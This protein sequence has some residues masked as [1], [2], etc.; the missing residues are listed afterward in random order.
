MKITL[1]RALKLRKE[2]EALLQKIELPTSVAVSLL[3]E[4][5]VTNP[6]AAIKPGTEALVKRIDNYL[7]LSQTLAALRTE[8][9]KANVTHGVEATL[10]QAAHHVRAM[11]IYKKLSSAGVT[12]VAEQLKAELAFSHQS[13]QNKELG[14]GRP[15]RSVNVSV[16]LP[17]L[18]DKAA[19]Q[20]TTWKRSLE[21][22]EDQRTGTNASVQIEI[23]EG[24]A[25]LLRQQGLI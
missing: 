12:P 8:I 9:A 24:D 7:G 17:E 10:A 20:Y 21:A 11:T 18:R 3:I 13:L 2:L 14:Y 25:E 5:N 4:D 15:D 23:A 22:L 6:E 19:E 1:K 16:V